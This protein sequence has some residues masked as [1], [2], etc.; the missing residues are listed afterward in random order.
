MEQVAIHGV[1]VGQ[2]RTLREEDEMEVAVVAYGTGS[3]GVNVRTGEVVHGPTGSDAAVDAATV[4]QAVFASAAPLVAV[5]ADSRAVAVYDA[6]TTP[7]SRRALLALPKRPSSVAF[8]SD[9][10]LVVAD[11][12]GDIYRLPIPPN[13][14]NTN[15]NNNNNK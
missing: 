7:W 15:N 2:L 5:A 3:V 13:T 12:F 8:A 10:D 9:L 4:K 14:N 1:F 11:K 6:S